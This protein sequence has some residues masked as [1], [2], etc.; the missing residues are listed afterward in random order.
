MTTA[1]SVW[2]NNLPTCQIGLSGAS[3]EDVGGTYTK[4]QWRCKMPSAPETAN[5]TNE[6]EHANRRLSY[7]VTPSTNLDEDPEE[8]NGLCAEFGNK[9]ISVQCLEVENDAETTHAFR[10]QEMMGVREPT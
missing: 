7:P 5:E 1:G 2:R 4:V 9:K 6:S 3:T 10:G 8:Q